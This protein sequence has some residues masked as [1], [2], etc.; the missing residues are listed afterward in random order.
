MRRLVLRHFVSTSVPILVIAEPTKG[1]VTGLNLDCGTT[2]SATYPQ[3]TSV[4]LTVIP[5]SGYTFTG[6]TGDCSGTANPLTINVDSA[7]NCTANFAPIPLTL[8]LT[9]PTHGKISASGLDCGTTCSQ[10]LPPGTK[11]PLGLEWGLCGN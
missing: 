6:W 5:E 4:E 10:P 9:P 1:K 2:C 7:K 8:T 11:I 3:P